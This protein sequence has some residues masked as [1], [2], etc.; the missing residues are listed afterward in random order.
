MRASCSLLVSAMLLAGAP[1]APAQPAERAIEEIVVT[2][3]QRT[4]SV[5][6]V[7]LSISSVTAEVLQ[8]G[9]IDRLQEMQYSVPNLVFGET[10]S[11]GETHIGLRGIGDFSRNIGFDTRVGVYIDDVFIGQSLAVDQ[12]LV[13]I[14]QID[15]L[16]GPQGT[17]FGKNTSS[18]VISIRTRRPEFNLT[19]G[20]FSVG[21]GNFDSR[22]GSAVLNVPLGEQAAARLSFIG[23]SQD[24]YVRNLTT[25]RDLMSN[26]HRQGRMRLRLQPAAGL[27]IDISADYGRQH[28]D[29]LFLEPSVDA[30]APGRRRVAQDGPLIDEN[31]RRGLGATVDYAFANGFVLTSISGFRDAERKVGSDEDGSPAYG[32]HVSHFEDEF[33]HLTQ[34]LR[35][36]SP[37]TAPLRYV[38]GAY[39]FRQQ[40]EQTRRALFG[41]GFGAPPDTLAALGVA[42]VDTDAWAG[43]I[44][45]DWDA[46]ENLTLSGGLRYTVESKDAKVSQF[47]SPAG[48]ADFPDYRDRFRDRSVTATVNAL[49]Q[50]HDDIALY[51]TYSRGHKSG[52]W[53]VDFIGG[54]EFLPFEEETVDSYEVGAKMELRDG[55]LRL[56]VAAFRAEYDDFQVFQFQ[57]AGPATLL[58][59]SNAAEVVTQGL[60]VEGLA[61]ITDGFEIAYGVGY[62][63]T[64]FDDFPGGAVDE[65]GAP[66][67][68]AGNR[69]P[70][71]PRLTSSVT[72]RYHFPVARAGHGKLAVNYAYRGEQYFNPDNRPNGRQGAYGLLGA[73]LDV[74]FAESWSVFLWGRNLTDRDYRVNRG[75]SFLGIPFDLWAQPRSWGAGFSYRF[76]R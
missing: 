2:A 44:N 25:G 39:L 17:L 56:N 62:A 3:R 24:G 75:V 45:A 15:V 4:E 47:G 23:Q 36:A 66:V 37:E 20:E 73:S 1:A 42:E 12:S 69:L 34:E 43:F 74:E 40:G 6:R 10:G 49:Y 55:R 13:D 22:S 14:A 54:T 59:V 30:D 70:R 8:E 53:N 51:A 32:L 21:A 76:Q 52:G 46:S 41:P 19:E 16:R 67:N 72:A 48:L 5:Q 50:A 35:L 29:T 68:V 31:R 61:R 71:A 64:E 60:E 9:R 65:A 57:S 27:D 11:S 26:D 33:T 7:P 38:L 18:G 28:N 63:R 58:V